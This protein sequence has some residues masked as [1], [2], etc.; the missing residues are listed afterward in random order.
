MGNAAFRDKCQLSTEPQRSSVSTG[1]PKLAQ[2]FNNTHWYD[3]N[4][5]S[6]KNQET[7]NVRRTLGSTSQPLHPS[8]FKAGTGEQWHFSGLCFKPTTNPQI[9]LKHEISF[10]V[11]PLKKKLGKHKS[12]YLSNLWKQEGYLLS[13]P[14]DGPWPSSSV[15]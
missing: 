13:K 7:K 1:S 10:Q 4:N 14:L 9:E 12:K 6:N 3:S 5:T 15:G 11:K 2:H 8:Q